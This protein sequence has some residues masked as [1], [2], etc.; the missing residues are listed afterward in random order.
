MQRLVIS[1]IKGYQYLI[2]PWLGR[3]CRFHPSCSEYSR[4]AIEMHGLYTG[5][6]LTLF[7]LLRCHPWHAGGVDPVPDELKRS[8]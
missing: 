6:R 3:H 7:R 1:L 8:T 5:I 4:Q 2:S